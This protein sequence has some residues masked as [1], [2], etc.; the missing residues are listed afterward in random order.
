M[1]DSIRPNAA[2]RGV[3]AGET[4]TITVE[5]PITDG[6]GGSTIVIDGEPAGK[7][8]RGRGRP[9]AVRAFPSYTS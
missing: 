7:L 9:I 8:R 3:G 5:R 6:F 1:P 4:A 2:E